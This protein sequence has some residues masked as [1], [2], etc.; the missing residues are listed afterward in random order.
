MC[1]RD[2]AWV[3]LAVNLP[4]LMLA[5]PLYDGR[6]DSPIYSETVDFCPPGIRP[7]INFHY[8]ALIFNLQS[9]PSLC[10][11]VRQMCLQGGLENNGDIYTHFMYIMCIM[12]IM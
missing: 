2:S 1:I 5:L 9:A 12:Y 8:A 7:G 6:T 11:C 4:C 3:K 10:F